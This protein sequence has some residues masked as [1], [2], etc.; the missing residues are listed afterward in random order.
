MNEDTKHRSRHTPVEMSSEEFKTAGYFLVDRIAE[1]LGSLPERKITPGE[2]PEDVKQLLSS[3]AGLPETGRDASGLLERA[4]GLLLDHSLYNGHPRF[5]G[6]I[7]SSP[8]PL[9]MLADLLAS[10]VNANVGAWKLA[11]MATE[12]EAQTVRWIAEFLGYPTEGDGLPVSG[13][14]MANFVCVLAARVDKAQWDVR[15]QG[16][17]AAASTMRVYATHET[18]TWIH[19]AADLF[20][21][22]TDAIRYIDTDI[23]Q[24]MDCLKL[25][26][27]IEQDLSA[28]DQPFLIVGSAGTVSTGV[29]DP[30]HE[31]AEIA[32]AFDLWFHVDGAYGAFAV[33]ADDV[34]E[35]LSGLRKA[36]SIAVD[37]HKWLYAPLEAGCALVR[38]KHALRDAFSYHPPYYHFD[39]ERTNYFELGL[40][41]SR[42]F[43]ALKV[44]LI[45]QQAGRRG[46][47]QMIAEDIQLAQHFF[48]RLTDYPSLEALTHGLSIATFRYLPLDLRETADAEASHNYL[49]E[50]NE[51]IMLQLEQEGEVFLSNAMIGGRF[52][53][54][55][56]IVNFRTSL[57]DI[58]ALPEIVVGVG[59]EI[60]LQM[61]PE[62]LRVST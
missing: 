50:L 46:Y 61:R 62:V 26:Q 48:D 54:R 11:P 12:I 53:L 10:A 52:A 1:L 22:G 51:K 33:A 57:E 6:Y 20:G 43:R 29:V 55:L 24:R 17:H 37:P 27:T 35:N 56:C 25:R 3:Q 49:N 36:D 16:M 45:L 15:R 19:K 5:W 60:D 34:A 31:M 2:S 30:L 13:G 44:W 47:A 42:G 59:D 4:V 18:H 41:N 7:T 39:P 14:N 38:K 40:Q 32:T 23:S 21:L 28:G 58:D 9:G 8:A